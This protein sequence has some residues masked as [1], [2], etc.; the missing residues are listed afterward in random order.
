MFNHP[1]FREKTKR[2]TD[3]A[4]GFRV[5]YIGW[6]CL[7]SVVAVI[8]RVD[9]GRETLHFD[10]CALLKERGEATAKEPSIL[11]RPTI[12]P[13]MILQEPLR[14]ERR[15]EPSKVTPTKVD[16]R[17]LEQVD[18]RLVPNKQPSLTK[19]PATTKT[20]TPT[21]TPSKSRGG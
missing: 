17:A 6:G 11:D 1:S 15:L 21:K 2:A 10:M 19:T 14:P 12:D 8:E 3:R 13:G 7:D 16:P 9:G 20:P 4:A 18:E 5:E